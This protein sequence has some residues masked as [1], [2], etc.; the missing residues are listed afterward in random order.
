MDDMELDGAS[1]VVLLVL[2]LLVGAVCMIDGCT[3]ET[4]TYDAFV[5]G[6]YTGYDEGTWYEI[7]VEV[8]STGEYIGVP[9]NSSEYE[10]YHQGQKVTLSRFHGGMMGFN[11]S[12]DI[13]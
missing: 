5:D 7:E 3:G 4:K 9:V 6:K 8:P 12:N 10:S 2:I 13:K 11:W 1:A